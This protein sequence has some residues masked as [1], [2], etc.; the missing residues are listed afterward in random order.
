MP[1]WPRLSLSRIS[2]YRTTTV[3]CKREQLRGLYTRILRTAI[4]IALIA[5]CGH[6]GVDHKLPAKDGAPDALGPTDA[7]VPGFCLVGT[8]TYPTIQSTVDDIA[9][10]VIS[11]PAGTW[12]ERLIVDRALEMFG[13][14]STQTVLDAGGLGRALDVT[15]NGELQLRAMAVTGGNAT[16]GA[17]IRVSGP[18]TLRD[19]RVFENTGAGSDIRGAGITVENVA[20][21]LGSGTQVDSNSLEAVGPGAVLLAGG[22][23]IHAQGNAAV[24]TI[25]GTVA[26]HDNGIVLRQDTISGLANGAGMYLGSGAQLIGDGALSIRDNRVEVSPVSESPVTSQAR[27]GGLFCED[28]SAN[29][30]GLELSGNLALSTTSSVPFAEAYGGGLAAYNCGI[31]LRQATVTDNEARAN[32]EDT[33]ANA[34]GGGVF[35]DTSTFALENSSITGNRVSTTLTG[36]VPVQG[37]CRGGGLYAKGT[38]VRISDSTLAGN[39][40]TG[41]ASVGSPECNGGA[42]TIDSAATLRTIA[43]IMRSTL[44]P[45][46]RVTATSTGLALTDA[47][48][49]ALA[50]ANYAS[51]QEI[52]VSVENSTIS[53]NSVEA[54]GVS[55]VSLGGGVSIDRSHEESIV[56]VRALQCTFSENEA[57]MPT[58]SGG[59]D[60]FTAGAAG[61]PDLLQLQNTL[62]VGNRGVE[63]APNCRAVGSLVVVSGRVY[64]EDQQFLECAAIVNGGAELI[65]DDSASLL[66]LAD[67]GGPT[68]THALGLA[69]TAIDSV[70]DATCVDLLDAPLLIDQRSQPRSSCDVGALEAQ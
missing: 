37:T 54:I 22:A 68:R 6:L 35:A 5:G 56:E 25:A 21:T 46:N 11:V 40:V 1:L 13:V 36:T 24:V 50:I 32:A 63:S 41:T 27:G 8:L 12:R 58:G 42:I 61:Y 64:V 2:A 38:D 7:L 4:G 65:T 53:G 15:A 70:P 67:N 29:L 49:G 28:S 62:L 55:T 69:S 19:V 3:P 16:T 23:G 14:S 34:H 51:N 60:A 9:C 44:G 39:S 45:N 52:L 10:L 20:L 26:I 17:G 59:I 48:G 57:F 18:T 30:I 43:T 31:T 33:L 66:P 47:R